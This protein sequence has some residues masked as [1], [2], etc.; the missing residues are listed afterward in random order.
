MSQKTTDGTN[1]LI[2]SQGLSEPCCDVVTMILTSHRLE[3]VVMKAQFVNSGGDDEESLHSTV[4]GVNH[5][6]TG[7]ESLQNS[8]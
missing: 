8:E 6:I 1:G 3:V 7:D 5:G 4:M 2:T